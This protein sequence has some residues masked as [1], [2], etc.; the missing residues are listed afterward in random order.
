MCYIA[1]CNKSIKHYFGFAKY[2][3]SLTSVL[4]QLSYARS[5]CK[6]SSYTLAWSDNL[7]FTGTYLLLVCIS[8][9]VSSI[10]IRLAGTNSYVVAKQHGW[11]WK[12]RTGLH[13]ILGPRNITNW[14]HQYRLQEISTVTID[15]LGTS[16]AK[17]KLSLEIQKWQLRW[18]S[19]LTRNLQIQWDMSASATERKVASASMGARFRTP[20]VTFTVLG[21]LIY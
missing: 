9:I 21:Y 12:L 1:C 10:K 3:N 11:K 16:R 13:R 14:R 4:L 15:T 5:W 8:Q 17:L 19:S 6:K 18:H 7:W 2:S 20:L